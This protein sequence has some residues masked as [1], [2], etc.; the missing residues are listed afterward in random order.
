LSIF[1]RRVPRDPP[2][3][4]YPT[5]RL[6]CTW[7]PR[8]PLPP[9]PGHPVAHTQL[10]LWPPTGRLRHPEAP[11]TG[12]LP[13]WGPRSPLP[14]RPG[15]PAAGYFTGPR[16]LPPRPGHPV[17]HTQ[18]ALWPPTGRRRHPKAPCTGRLP[19]RRATY[20]R[21]PAGS[22]PRGQFQR[23]LG[24]RLGPIPRDQHATS[25]RRLSSDSF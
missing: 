23:V 16:S 1:R 7:G 3:R 24:V 4:G 19:C 5:A 21:L 11:C 6:P 13:C 12:R 17:A 14:P 22:Q 9:R 18:L 8:S 25:P 10:A 15:H 20:T 2:S